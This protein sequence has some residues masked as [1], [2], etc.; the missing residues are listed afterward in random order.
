MTKPFLSQ[1]T[2]IIIVP[3][4]IEFHLLTIS[5]KETNVKEAKTSFSI[6]YQHFRMFLYNVIIKN[7]SYKSHKEEFSKTILNEV[8]YH[9]WNNPLNW[10][11]KSENHKSPDSAF[12][13]YLST[14]AYY[15]RM[16]YLRKNETYL[17]NETP[18]VD[19]PNNDWLFNLEIEE[20]EVLENELPNNNNM[21]DSVLS[22]LDSKKRDIVR[23][24]FQHYEE[25]K[26]MRS[27][28]IKLMES[29]FNTT[30]DNIRQIISRVKKQIKES[31]NKTIKVQ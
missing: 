18:K 17:K 11:Y 21:L 29:M 31:T 12:K 8:F 3:M 20:Y 19:D 24:Y 22:N 7:I 5:E 25:G 16:E 27:E 9:I 13:A 10:E 14:I 28:N 15:K 26:K 4:D 30:W 6:I 23:V 2:H 1:K